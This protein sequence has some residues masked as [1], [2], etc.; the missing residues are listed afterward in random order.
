MLGIKLDGN[1]G[2]YNDL[3]NSILDIAPG[4]TWESIFFI[5]LFLPAIAVSCRRLHDIGKS[6]WWQ[7]IYLTGIGIIILIIWWCREGETTKKEMHKEKE[8]YEE[9][10]FFETRTSEYQTDKE[11]H[12]SSAEELKKWAELRDTGAITEREYQKKK[13]ELIK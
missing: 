3:D 10:N 1:W 9:K 7:L 5:I 4:A 13:E 2:F 11:T 6:G 8:T 12:S